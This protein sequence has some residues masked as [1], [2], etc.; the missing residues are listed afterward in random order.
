MR[1]KKFFSSTAIM[2]AVS[3]FLIPVSSQAVPVQ[4]QQGDSFRFGIDLSTATP[5]GPYSYISWYLNTWYTD[6]ID[7]GDILS[8]ALYDDADPGTALGTD[9]F[10]WTYGKSTLSLGAMM[11]SD[12]VFDGTGF[13]EFTMVSGSIDLFGGMVYGI[14]SKNYTNIDGLTDITVIPAAKVSVP[15]PNTLSMLGLGLLLVFFMVK[16]KSRSQNNVIPSLRSAIV[17]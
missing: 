3:F 2:M 12:P 8:V 10:N 16:M 14:V 7:T 4:I 6:G 5:T 9:S 1:I 17:A 13:L 11:P 15:E